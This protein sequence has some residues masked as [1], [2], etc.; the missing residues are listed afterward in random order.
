ME[1]TMILKNWQ[2]T[3]T[4]SIVST[5]DIKYAPVAVNTG[6]LT[7]IFLTCIREFVMTQFNNSKL[8]LSV[9]VD[10]N[11]MERGI[12]ACVPIV[13]MLFDFFVVNGLLFKPNKSASGLFPKKVTTDAL[14]DTVKFSYNFIGYLI[15]Y[16]FTL[17]IPL[18][19]QLSPAVVAYVMDKMDSNNN[20][21]NNN[22]T[23]KLNIT[24]EDKKF[25]LDSKLH[26]CCMRAGAE[27]ITALPFY[28]KIPAPILFDFFY[29][30][31]ANVSIGGLGTENFCF[32]ENMNESDQSLIIQWIRLLDPISAMKLT[33]LI[34]NSPTVS[35]NTANIV[36]KK[37][38]NDKL[39]I[40]TCDTCID[41]PACWLTSL[42]I[43]LQN[44]SIQ[45]NDLTF[46][47]I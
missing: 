28:G 43:L 10:N 42:D 24:C 18:Q 9:F 5:H 45:L 41:L 6:R 36:F 20:N 39:S 26:L 23:P 14:T 44:M 35:K 2:L 40:S 30:C 4:E 16:V 31:S 13:N 37:N 22:N 12:S 27:K 8:I 3:L 15:A 1:A 11:S 21:I 46:N 29:N 25:L 32:D 17:N 47:K 7:D 34:T 38:N 33:M 19:C